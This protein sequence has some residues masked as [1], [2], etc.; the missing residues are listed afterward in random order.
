MNTLDTPSPTPLPI[1]AEA[2]S[3]KRP[4]FDPILAELYAV[5]AEL[6][7]EAGYSVEN[8]IER[9]RQSALRAAAANLLHK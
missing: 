4:R 8:I 1:A 2:I 6:N 9:A 5:K 7:K 3:T